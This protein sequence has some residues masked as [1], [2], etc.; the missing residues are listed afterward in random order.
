[1]L[2]QRH[3]ALIR[4]ALQ[5]FDEELVPHGTKATR[6]YLDVAFKRKV[7]AAEMQDLR[8]YLRDVGL[9]YGRYHPT[10]RRLSDTRLRRSIPQASLSDDEVSVIV[11]IPQPH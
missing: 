5:F 8:A 6:P 7:T 10:T 4:A 3:L 2:T 9:T 11:L 1:M